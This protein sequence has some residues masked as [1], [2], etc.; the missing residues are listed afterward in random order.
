[1][2]YITPLDLGNAKQDAR[3]IEKFNN[4]PIGKENISRLGR[5]VSNLAT[6]KA[7]ALEA[8][9]GAANLRIYL[10]KAAMEAD[11][12]QPVPTSGRVTNDPAVANNGDYVWNGTGWIRSEIQ[13]AS[14][15][16]M[17]TIKPKVVRADRLV[18]PEKLSAEY[19]TGWFDEKGRPILGIRRR[20]GRLLAEL[21]DLPGRKVLSAIWR[22][23][24][25]D[26][27]LVPLRGLRWD[28][29]SYEISGPKYGASAFIRHGR[30][31]VMVGGAP[32]QLSGA[33]NAM[34]ITRS[35]EVVAV[36]AER[37]GA[38]STQETTLPAY[39]EMADFVESLLLLIS[40]G[41][42]LGGGSTAVPILT[43]TPPL[44]NRIYMPSFGVRLA[45][46]DSTVTT[47]EPLQPLT[48]TTAEVPVA[49]LAA[50]LAR[51]DG[52]PISS[53]LLACSL[54]RGGAS[55]EMLRK[56][57]GVWY[58]NVME[59]ITLAKVYAD[60]Q[61]L[62]FDFRLMPFTHGETNITA[63]PGYYT[64][65][66]LALQGDEVTP[67][68]NAITGNTAPVV[69]LV[70]Q[71]SS[72]TAPSYN[73]TQSYVPF[74]QLQVALDH[75]DRFVCSGPKYWLNYQADG[76]HLVNEASARLGCLQGEVVRAV[77]SGGSWLPTHCY[78]AERTGAVIDLH[79]HTPSGRLAVDTQAVTDPGHWG[80]RWVD[81][82]N[83]AQIQSVRLLGG[84]IV[85]VLLNQAPTGASG[86]IGIAD[87][88][89]AGQ[90]AGPTTGPRS[91]LR[92]AD[93][94][95]DFN[96][97]PLY[98]WACHQRITVS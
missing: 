29:T 35:A 61:G 96:G 8:A 26:S 42:S 87:V 93:S 46:Y 30:P 78:K 45:N 1:M 67:D 53:A 79:F 92:S 16:D 20:D 24:E 32:H 80:L 58:D 7:Q 3:T 31:F 98:H 12:G 86:F 85:R 25:A 44:A 14:A 15:A 21:Q 76:V 43:T 27:D 39:G 88:G 4:D 97:E 70:D 95:L 81:S 5:D 57:G 69:F 19:I 47:I 9:A 84:N 66:L 6:I 74:E 90:P 72:W 56:G 89:V 2:K 71:V 10:T 73:L 50:Q 40:Y 17:A 48:A 63:S 11:T 77:L 68:A 38:I 52:L 41:Q 49:Q 59:T 18:I 75:P 55:I 13:P 33:G 94:T 22:Y 23:V 51:S 54:A 36:T 28:G 65:Q 37:K 64:A 82:T 62:G 60:A 91:C 34:A 83:S